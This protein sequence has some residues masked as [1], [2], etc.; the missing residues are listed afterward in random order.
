M[1]SVP[2]RLTALSAA[3]LLGAPAVP[4]FAEG[5]TATYRHN[6][7]DFGGTI[8]FMGVRLH[9]DGERDEA[10]VFDG[11]TI[12]IFTP[13]G[14]ETFSIE[15]GSRLSRIF[16]LAVGPS[17]DIFLLGVDDLQ[18]G[19]FFI[20]RC[21][22]R[23]APG[24]RITPRGLPERL[25]GF[26]PNHMAIHDGRFV[27]V[28]SAGFVAVVLTESGAFERAIEFFDMLELSPAQRASV[29]VAGFAVAPD[30]SLLFTIPEQFAVLVVRPDGSH[31]SFG[32]GGSRAGE[33]GVVGGI[34]VDSERRVFVSD[35]Q[36]SVVLVF[37]ENFEFVTEFGGYGDQPDSLVR[38]DQVAVSPSGKLYVTQMRQRGISVFEIRPSRAE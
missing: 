32:K 27:L 5:V 16:D 29:Q 25:A 33:F 11:S 17:G 4:A 34:A 20:E 26:V 14:M 31:V 38:P 15:V 6:L 7:A 1:R 8:P 24:Q 19:E 36:R 12:R 21:D 28:S 10:Y 35:K 30:G 2:H 23:G 37:D 18:S 13:T 22:F 9:L 3:L